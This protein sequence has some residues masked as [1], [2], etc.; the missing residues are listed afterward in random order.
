[1]HITRSLSRRQGAGTR[2]AVVAAVVAL[3]AATTPAAHAAPSDGVVRTFDAE[4]IGA[5][6]VGC[7]SVGD[8]VVAAAAFGGASTAN[9]AL[10]V[11]DDATG[12]HTRTRCAFDESPQRSIAFRI[13]TA[14]LDQPAIIAL[15][16]AAG[17]SSN[18]VFRFS[19]WADGEDGQDLIIKAY[20]GSAWRTV[21]AVPQGAASGE[22][23]SVRIN[24][25]LE[26]AEVEIDGVRA[27]TTARASTSTALGDVFFASAGTA[28]VGTDF[29][30]DD[31]AVDAQ[32]SE[33]AFTSVLLEGALPATGI[34][35][36][37]QLEATPVAR[38]VVPEG[39][40]AS[41]F[42]ASVEFGGET[43]PAVISP[44]DASGSAA[45]SVTHT[46]T[47]SGAVLVRTLVTHETGVM[48]QSA[49]Q[50][51]VNA[52][53]QV[54]AATA[55]AGLSIRFPSV[56]MLDDGRLLAAYHEAS[57]HTNANG[58]IRVISSSDGGVSWSTPSTAVDIAHDARDPKLVE[59][60]DGTLLMSY[61]E[62]QWTN[63]RVIQTYVVRSVDG[64]RTW[65]APEHVPTSGGGWTAT[66]GPIVE[67][68]GGDLLM[69]LYRTRDDDPRQRATVVRSTDGGDTWDI[70]NEVTV[71][72]GSVN[73][74]EPNL[75]VLPSGEIVALIRTDSSPVRAY[76]S[77][78][79]DDGFTWTTPI[80]TDIPA[81]SHDQLLLSTGQVLLTYGDRSLDRRPTSGTLI[82]DPAGSWD[83]YAEDSILLYDSGSGDQ[84]NPS[85][86][87][88]APGRFLTLGYSVGARSLVAVFTELD[89]YAADPRPRLALEPSVA[90][91][92]I[93]GDVFLFVSVLN[94]DDVRA[95]LTVTSA[96]S[97]REFSDARP[98]TTTST[99]FR[100]GLSSLGAGAV[101]VTGSGTDGAAFS[102]AVPY[103]AT[104]CE[105]QPG[106]DRG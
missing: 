44:P 35:E 59:L 42:S 53:R 12:V 4:A 37:D 54:V 87:E 49:Q 56:V 31:L 21:G 5:P 19:F 92:C 2:L 13:S 16:G 101:A 99:T 70:T 39:R 63:P 46:V 52:Y 28:P 55:P 102:A 47:T 43:I 45:I 91:R 83:G 64:G 100:T 103:A 71:A 11:D 88:L 105:W 58:D 14:Q 41:E 69:P 40:D 7:A 23:L 106:E 29:Y 94:A 96:Q 75:T 20:D 9:R 66:H 93:A 60:S 97:R 36:G 95:D 48:S 84:A 57:A 77:R 26:R 22:W 51:T 1:M 81:E 32:L 82:H 34:A 6:P 18:G 80:V 104:T 50:I 8:V 61:F 15:M 78:S 73:F 89:D 85:S 79:F 25:T 67:L 17:G 27:Q 74:Q 10:R 90:T 98:D 65:S 38:F 72:V 33:T 76:L 30:I 68:A 86:V 24:A 62:Y 3:L